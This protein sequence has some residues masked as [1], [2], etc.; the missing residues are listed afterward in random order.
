MDS[1]NRLLKLAK[2][3][4]KYKNHNE[5]K[6]ISCYFGKFIIKNSNYILKK[7][8]DYNLEDKSPYFGSVREF[9]KKYPGGIIDF[10]KMEDKDT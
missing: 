1:F 4:Y 2:I 5:L 9:L 8:L 3:Y 6:K 10:L 7:N